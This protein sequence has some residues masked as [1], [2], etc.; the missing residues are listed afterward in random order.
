MNASATQLHTTMVQYSGHEPEFRKQAR[1]LIVD[2]LKFEIK[3][4]RVIPSHLFAFQPTVYCPHKWKLKAMSAEQLRVGMTSS[5]QQSTATP[6]PFTLVQMKWT[7]NGH[8]SSEEKAHLQL[9]SSKPNGKSISPTVPSI[10]DFSSMN[11]VDH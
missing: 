11:N 1:Q 3:F 2:K 6:V 9:L 7:A 10:L 4:N 5:I 8:Y